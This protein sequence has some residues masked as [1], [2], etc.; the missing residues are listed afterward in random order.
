V[1][2]SIILPRHI[3]CVHEKRAYAYKTKK[4][5]NKNNIQMQEDTV[6]MSYSMLKWGGLCE[7]TAGLAV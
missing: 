4:I 2:G 1:L 7:E 3:Y 6:L 5:Y